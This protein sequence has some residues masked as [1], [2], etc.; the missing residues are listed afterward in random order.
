MNICFGK[1]P[2]EEYC[3][4]PPC[5]ILNPVNEN[6]YRWVKLFKITNKAQIITKLFRLE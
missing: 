5:G 1:E 3:A 6:M 4:E 2:W